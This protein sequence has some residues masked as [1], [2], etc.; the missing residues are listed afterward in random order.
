MHAQESQLDALRTSAKSAPTDAAAA[1]ALGR[2]LHRAGHE[3]DAIHELRR[4]AMLPG[5]RVGDT[6]LRLH[7]EIA[8]SH[9]ALRDF[10]AAMVSCGALGALPGVAAGRQQSLACTAE[11]RLVWQ[12]SSEALADAAQALAGGNKLYDAKVTEGR[13]HDLALDDAKAEAA[14]REAIAWKPDAP[15]GHMYLGRVLVK[16]AKKDEGLAELRKATQLDPSGPDAA[17]EL[18]IA[19]GPNAEAAQMLD[20]ATRERPGFTAAWLKLADVSLALGK[21]AD[22]KRAAEATLRLSPNE[23]AAHLALGKVA[24]AEGRADDAIRAASSAL[25]L[26]ANSAQAKLLLADAYVKKDE[27][28]L[29]LEA[30]QAAWGLDHA[31]PTPLVHASEACHAGGRDTSARA[32]AA[33][34]TQE[35]PRWAPGWAALGDA[36]VGQKEIA[37]A[38]VAYTNALTGEGPVDRAA[39]QRKLGALK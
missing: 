30:Y 31:D 15:E 14:L 18:A 35:F 23:V 28:D 9:M 24:L 6:A 25:K 20:R 11:A 21:L 22:A 33:R 19:L 27:L 38:K 36:L 29:A 34:A 3:Q 16:G 39:V 10:G 17:Y 2:A 8:R 13:A 1:L 32:F 7:W 26:T 37:A 4:G 5:G 12:L